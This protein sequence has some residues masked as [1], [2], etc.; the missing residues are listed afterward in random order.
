MNI[1]GIFVN[2]TTLPDFIQIYYIKVS[3]KPSLQKIKSTFID[4]KSLLD[5][6]FTEGFEISLDTL[7]IFLP[8]T[9][10]ISFSYTLPKIE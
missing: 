10:T 3:L 5:L 6:I 2:L 9:A 4:M 1:L 8:L 7:G